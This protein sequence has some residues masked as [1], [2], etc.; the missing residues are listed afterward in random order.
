[1]TA[2]HVT[3][4]VVAPA[5]WQAPAAITETHISVLVSIGDR[6]Y[7]LKKPV[8]FG[9]LD[10]STREARF[11]ACRAEV[12]LNRRLSP[13]VYLG[14][15][16]VLGPDGTPCDHLVAMRRMPPERRLAAL[17]RAGADVDGEL[18]Q[19]ARRV[20]A[21]H[22][23]A[24]TSPEISA[25]ASRDAVRA[26]WD[27]GFEQ[28]VPFAGDV[29]DRDVCSRV[30]ELVHRYLDGREPLFRARIGGGHV[31]D[32]H[33]DLQAED[34]F[35]LDDGPRILDCIEFDPNLRYGDVLADVAFL[36]MDLER[37]GDAAAAAR[38]LARYRE[39]TGET[40]PESLASHYIAYRA[41]V[42]TK[43]A[44]LR[45][46]QGDPDSADAARRLLA[47]SVRHLE[48]ARVRLV[49][50]GGAP[51]TGKS[52][53]AAGVAA[54]R[55][56]TLLRSDEIRKD[57]AGVAEGQRADHPY[58]EGLYR[59]EATA[60]VYRVMLDQA[61]VALTMGESVVLDASWTDTRWREAAAAVAQDTV[62]DFVAVRCQA[63]PDVAAARI[64]ARRRAGVDP[65][66][67]T[68]EI[69]ERMRKAATPWPEAVT[70]DTTGPIDATVA[71][72]LR[73]V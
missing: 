31:R 7:K 19:V 62:S 49:L 4:E 43:V 20:A 33:G 17:V 68:V 21:F 57:L 58:R 35:C 22:A 36:A 59:P 72:A 70:L 39:F 66:D 29:L 69:A 38:F 63:P 55:G 54:A 34:V 12:E 60:E 26:H 3:G 52:T 18:T 41:H 16:D 51:G 32:G 46:A 71:E 5:E 6:V 30:E 25:A 50:V 40:Y 15:L 9:F 67:A 61:R 73:A 1:M 65:S 42:R 64:D 8:S 2:D 14:V 37:L 13:D 11:A 27:A 45:S 47:L 56:W 44:C 23:T 53:V 24:E 10:F 28:L 48:F